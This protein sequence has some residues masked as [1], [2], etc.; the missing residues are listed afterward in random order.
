MS[1]PHETSVEYFPEGLLP[2]VGN[3]MPTYIIEASKPELE[4]NGRLKLGR[5]EDDLDQFDAV[6]MRIEGIGAVLRR[7]DHAPESGYTLEIDTDA[8]ARADL[9]VWLLSEKLLLALGFGPSRIEWSNEELRR[10][11]SEHAG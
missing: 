2:T 4:Q 5:F 1:Y 10:M 11:L 3:F 8:A 7:Y 6:F 9:N